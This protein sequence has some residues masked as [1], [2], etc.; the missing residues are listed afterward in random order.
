VLHFHAAYGAFTHS[1]FGPI[2]AFELNVSYD[3]EIAE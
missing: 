3:L 1:L 2:D